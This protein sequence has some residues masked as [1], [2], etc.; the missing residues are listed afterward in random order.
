MHKS[1]TVLLY[2]YIAYVISRITSNTKLRFW[3]R[4]GLKAK[5]LG[6]STSLAVY[7]R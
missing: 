3:L 1:M 5:G 2:M 7:I 4:Q 6:L